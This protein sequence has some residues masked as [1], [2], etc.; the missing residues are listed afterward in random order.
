MLIVYQSIAST[1]LENVCGSAKSKLKT[2]SASA[3]H[4]QGIQKAY[5]ILSVVIIRL[6]VTVYGLDVIVHR[7]DVLV[8]G[9]VVH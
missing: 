8:R 7:L 6:G 1:V 5:Y 2:A 9:P 3:V 4:C